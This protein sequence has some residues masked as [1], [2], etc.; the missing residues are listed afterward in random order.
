MG[1]SGKKEQKGMTL[2]ELMVVV[3]IIG[4]MGAISYP[5]YR[6]Y[7]NE[8]RLSAA[9]A[10]AMEI[11]MRWEQYYGDFRKYNKFDDSPT[12][13]RCVPMVGEN[14]VRGNFSFSCQSPSPAFPGDN[15]T[16]LLSVTGA[17][18]TPFE[19]LAYTI[20]HVGAKDTT[21]T[22]WGGTCNRD[23]VKKWGETC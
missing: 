9:Q 16:Y 8:S 13:N 5:A 4:I 23:W 11:R 17:A 7:V 19:G 6:N 10:A 12:I 22:P 20:D 14:N 15:N 3:A 21:G 2:I 1:G 18:G